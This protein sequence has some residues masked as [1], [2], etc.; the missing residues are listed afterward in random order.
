MEEEPA[1]SPPVKDLVER[2][3][4]LAM[5]TSPVTSQEEGEMMQE[6]VTP[7]LSASHVRLSVSDGGGGACFD[8]KRRGAA[9]KQSTPAS[10]SGQSSITSEG[11]GAGLSPASSL[12]CSGGPRFDAAIEDSSTRSE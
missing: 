4:G 10:L 6:C 12:E 9:A 1:P 2:E 7:S 3:E 11:S 8:V 5:S